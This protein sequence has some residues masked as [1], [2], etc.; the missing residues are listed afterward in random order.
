M[1]AVKIACAAAALVAC[2]G[3]EKN[4]PLSDHPQPLSVNEHMQEARRH[5][6][7][8]ERSDASYDPERAKSSP[9]TP[10]CYADPIE[11][12]ST[13]GGKPLEIMRPCWTSVTN[14]TAHHLEDAERNR[15]EAEA[16]RARAAALIGAEKRACAGL[17]PSSIDHSP[18][19][20]R[21]DVLET[22][23]V[24]DGNKIRGARALF[25][26]VPGLTA[27]WLRRAASCHQARAAVMGYSPTFMPYCPLVVAPS[28]VTVTE[29]DAGLWLQI[30][31]KDSGA[32]IWDRARAYAKNKEKQP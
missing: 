26:R 1:T 19:F 5:D 21:E 24:R 32:A 2:G 9:R 14:P 27:D 17:A 18:F 30:T 6:A 20:H 15:R 25:A 8:A 12:Q 29:S 4:K 28:K 13:S 10:Q 11:G 31:S 16:H 23:P 7:A 22:E 3:A